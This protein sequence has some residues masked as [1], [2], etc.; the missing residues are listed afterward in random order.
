MIVIVEAVEDFDKGYEFKIHMFNDGNCDY[1]HIFPV[2]YLKKISRNNINVGSNIKE[3][4][5]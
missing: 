1:G 3:T 4:L 2:K 5:K